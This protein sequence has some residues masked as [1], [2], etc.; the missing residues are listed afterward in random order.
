M[1]GVSRMVKHILIAL[2][3]VVLIIFVINRLVMGGLALV[4]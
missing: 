4:L 3:L 2:G 1:K